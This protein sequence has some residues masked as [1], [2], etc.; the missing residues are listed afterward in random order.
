MTKKTLPNKR[1]QMSLPKINRR[2]M[3]QAVLFFSSFC[4]CLLYVLE[5]CLPACWV[6]SSGKTQY[7]G[8]NSTKRA[9]FIFLSGVYTLVTCLALGYN[10][11]DFQVPA[12][13]SRR[14]NIAKEYWIQSWCTWGKSGGLLV[15]WWRHFE[16]TAGQLKPFFRLMNCSWFF[17]VF[18]SF[19][20]FLA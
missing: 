18:Y 9:L 17:T 15:K 6:G 3:R 8:A 10:S 19:F 13:T 5:I 7:H 16:L 1:T 11:A 20:F 12:L 4:A 14:F 2:G